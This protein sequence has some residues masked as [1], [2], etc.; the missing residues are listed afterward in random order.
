M[1]ALTMFEVG[2]VTRGLVIAAQ[3]FMTPLLWSIYVINPK[4]MHRFVGYL[5]ETAC[6]TYANIIRQVETEGTPLN[7]AWSDLPAPDIAKGYWHLSGD[8][9]WIDALKCMFAD[10][11]NHRD[12]NHTFAT[13]ETDDPNPFI[14][15]HLED[16]AA[17]WRI[18]AEAVVDKDL[19]Y[20]K[21]TPQNKKLE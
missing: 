10:E 9:L 18:D 11:A 6:E 15:K 5:E 17:A 7:E 12:V 14:T 4:M 8:A 1:T 16:A 21:F 2:P 20:G 19:T 13:M 3:C